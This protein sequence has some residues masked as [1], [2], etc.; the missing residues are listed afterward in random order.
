MKLFLRSK[1]IAIQK[2]P[3]TKE[4][5][6]N[7]LNN[8]LSKYKLETEIIN[9]M[10]D[11]DVVLILENGVYKGHLICGLLTLQS[12]RYNIEKIESRGGTLWK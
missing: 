2:E 1:I 6:L 8:I 12:T 11:K 7:K 9:I 3:Y 10:R 5:F 4:E